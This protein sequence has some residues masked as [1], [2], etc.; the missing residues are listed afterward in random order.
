[1]P[2][3]FVGRTRR[4]DHIC[5]A[6][7]EESPNPTV[8]IEEP[9]VV[10]TAVPPWALVPTESER[11]PSLGGTATG[12]PRHVAVPRTQPGADLSG[13]VRPD[14]AVSLPPRTRPP[15][16]TRGAAR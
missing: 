4:I 10:R 11:D 12:E 6:L 14:D 8:I 16:W 15:A 1:M 7:R 9:S 13:G 2:W 5:A 3:Q